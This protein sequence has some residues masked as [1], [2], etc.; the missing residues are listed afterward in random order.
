MAK[1]KQQ[2]VSAEGPVKVIATERGYYGRIREPG[3][4]FKV[5]NKTHL[6][7]WM[8]PYTGDTPPSIEPEEP[9]EEFDDPADKSVI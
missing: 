4:T 9:E 1:Q 3:E 2:N 7:K 8:I 6:G 5:R